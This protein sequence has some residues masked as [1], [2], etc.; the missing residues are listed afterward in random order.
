MFF[1]QKLRRLMALRGDGGSHLK[2]RRFAETCAHL[3]AL[4]QRFAASGMREMGEDARD[5]EE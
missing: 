3:L 2:K 1:F 4:T 5:T